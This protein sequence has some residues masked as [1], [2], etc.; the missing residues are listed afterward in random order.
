VMVIPLAPSVNSCR[1][2]LTASS[3][4]STAQF[5]SSSSWDAQHY[6]M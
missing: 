6:L 3:D 1:R 4:T 5:P 2:A